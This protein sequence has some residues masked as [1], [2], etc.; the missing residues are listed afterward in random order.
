MI[1]LFFLSDIYFVRL[2]LQVIQDFSSVSGLKLNLNKTQG[3][4]IEKNVKF[5][6][7]ECQE[8][9]IIWSQKIEILGISFSYCADVINSNFERIIDKAKGTNKTWYS[10]SLTI[11]GRIPLVKLL[12]NSLLQ[13]IRQVFV[14]PS[15]VLQ[16]IE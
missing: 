9:G 14:I 8:L 15:K 2:I 16:E 7:A 5:D 12:I 6:G 13:Y 10:R 4:G 3:I 1:L 11:Y